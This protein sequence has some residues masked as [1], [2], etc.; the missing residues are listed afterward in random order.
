MQPAAATFSRCENL[1]ATVE[2]IELCSGEVRALRD[3]ETVTE[4]APALIA[5]TIVPAQ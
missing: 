4:T 5:A 2:E 3:T 1:E